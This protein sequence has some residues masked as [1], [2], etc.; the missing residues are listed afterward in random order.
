MK[1]GIVLAVTIMGFCFFSPSI[2]LAEETNLVEILSINHAKISA[3]QETI[4][5]KLGAPR[6]CHHVFH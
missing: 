3:D 1:L 2:L 5:F 6:S 4:S